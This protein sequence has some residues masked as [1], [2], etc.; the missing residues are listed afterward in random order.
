MCKTVCRHKLSIHLDKY[1]RLWLLNHML[2]V[3][4]VLWET[5]KLSYTVAAPFSISS[6][7]EGDF[8]LLHTLI[9]VGF[10]LNFRHSSSCVVVSHLI[11]NSLKIYDIEHLFLCLFAS[12]KSSLVK[13]RFWSIKYVFDKII[14]ENFPIL[15]KKHISR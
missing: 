14:L 2:R 11:C 8:L 12:C 5:D 10:I 9:R 6:I 15:K 13:G 4:L 3:C 1:Q 7:N